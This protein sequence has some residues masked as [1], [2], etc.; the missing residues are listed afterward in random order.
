MEQRR[1]LL[2]PL[3]QKRE[4]TLED[5]KNSYAIIENNHSE[6][7]TIE[8]DED[9]EYLDILPELY[10]LVDVN[11]KSCITNVKRL[12]EFEVVYKETAVKIF[13]FVWKKQTDG[14]L[15]NEDVFWFCKDFYEKTKEIK[16]YGTYIKATVED[17]ICTIT[18]GK[19]MIEFKVSL[20]AIVKFYVLC[21]APRM[22]MSSF[23]DIISLTPEDVRNLY[24][25]FISE[26]E[27]HNFF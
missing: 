2:N 3:E 9:S 27:K 4:Y 26:G 6:Q 15:K 7:N 19:E 21:C 24:D 14:E 17:D 10:D 23:E 22:Y 12:A 1:I 13:T 25:V 11:Y 16:K 18:F 8:N 5:F 20:W